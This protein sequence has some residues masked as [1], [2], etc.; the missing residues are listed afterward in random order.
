MPGSPVSSAVAIGRSA[1]QSGLR[2]V[3]GAGVG[4][5][6]SHGAEGCPVAAKNISEREP[7]SRGACSA[8]R[9]R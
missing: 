4:S 7:G 2:S 1:F 3:A 8:T 5:N 6:C 9:Q